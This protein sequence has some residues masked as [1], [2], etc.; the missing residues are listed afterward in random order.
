M[1]EHGDRVWGVCYFLCRAY[2]LGP[3]WVW[4]ALKQLFEG[5]EEEWDSS[6]GA[7]Q[8]FGPSAPRPDEEQLRLDL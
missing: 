7:P 2:R 8:L 6:G 4:G 5:F 3:R 1:Y